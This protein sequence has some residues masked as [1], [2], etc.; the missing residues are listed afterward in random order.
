LVVIAS[1]TR[2]TR[3][4]LVEVVASDGDVSPVFATAERLRLRSD[5]TKLK[6]K[7]GD[8]IRAVNGSAPDKKTT[9][10]DNLVYLD[11]VRGAA[12]FIVRVSH[13]RGPRS[14]PMQPLR[15]ALT[16]AYKGTAVGVRFTKRVAT[17]LDAA[18][19]VRKIDGVVPTT[20]AQAVAAF[21]K[22]M[23][24]QPIVLETERMGMPSQITLVLMGTLGL[25]PRSRRSCRR[26]S[27]S[28][29]PNTRCR[30]RCSS[31]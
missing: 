5:A 28:R 16:R 1:F 2:V 21:T 17:E 9:E 29:R 10:F 18:T 25:G 22:G 13:D 19:L 30:S 15:R 3:A 26:S 14:V 6:L 24:N 8:V 4:D 11:V 12:T 7:A 23:A 20:A 31:G 27:R